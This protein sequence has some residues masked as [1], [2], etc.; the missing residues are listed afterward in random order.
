MSRPAQTRRGELLRDLAPEWANALPADL[1]VTGIATSVARC[2]PGDLLFVSE[3]ENLPRALQMAIRRGAAAVVVTGDAPPCDLPV[4]CVDDR[5]AAF[6]SVMRRWLAQLSRTMKI[7]GVAGETGKTSTAYL[8]AS[9]L[10]NADQ[11]VGIMGSLGCCDGRDVELN[12]PSRYR[13]IDLLWWLLRMSWN[14]CTHAILELGE[15]VLAA[16]AVRGVEFDVVCVTNRRLGQSRKS[17]TTRAVLD[18]LSFHGVAVL[19]A[20]DDGAAA[21]AD[22]T[23]AATITVGVREHA[24]ITATCIEKLVSEQ[25]FLLNIGSDSTVVRVP[26]PGEHNLS[27]CLVAAAVGTVYGINLADLARGLES[28]RSMPGRL[29]RIECGQNFSVFVDCAAASPAVERVIEQLRP[30]VPGRIFCVSDGENETRPAFPFLRSLERDDALVSVVPSNAGNKAPGSRKSHS[31]AK[32]RIVSRRMGTRLESI[33]WALSQAKA[34][35]CVL[36]AGKGNSQPEAGD[37][38]A[39]LSDREIAYRWLYRSATADGAHPASA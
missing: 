36:I 23:G 10:E 16:P 2:E 39:S 18:Q 34:G 38:R 19:N 25:T 24:E 14:G 21:L 31:S 33:E 5:R 30:L 29:E 12:R 26:L 1:R 11:R 8:L 20:D 28:V 32:A 15:S 6:R 27:N 13:S 35:D 3:E 37:D 22:D 9:V 17:D 4:V 7:V